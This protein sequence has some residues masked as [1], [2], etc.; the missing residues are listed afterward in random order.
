MR[1]VLGAQGG[2]LWDASCARH[3]PASLA[4]GGAAAAA[5]AAV[6]SEP[7]APSTRGANSE[8]T[9]RSCPSTGGEH[10]PATKGSSSLGG[11]RAKQGCQPAFANA[12]NNDSLASL[13]LT[14]QSGPG[15]QILQGRTQACAWQ[16]D[17]QR[18][19]CSPGVCVLSALSPRLAPT[20]LM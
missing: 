1:N 11:A 16:G 9:A 5:A 6:T 3:A 14:T 17:P 15:H 4:G 12:R 10:S 19:D 7:S 20:T 13:L 18:G 2:R 8:A